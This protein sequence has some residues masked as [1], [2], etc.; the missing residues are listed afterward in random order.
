MISEA[1]KLLNIKPENR[2]NYKEKQKREILERS[3]TKVGNK[4]K[5]KKITEINTAQEKREK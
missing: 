4:T 2:Q 3:V 1:L 5:D